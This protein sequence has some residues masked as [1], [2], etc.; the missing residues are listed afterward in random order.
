MTINKCNYCGST[1]TGIDCGLCHNEPMEADK[2]HEAMKAFIQQEQVEEQLSNLFSLAK[3]MTEDEFK[4]IVPIEARKL[5][6][7]VL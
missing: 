4:A 7:L 5:L 3:K 2:R 1:K 6:N